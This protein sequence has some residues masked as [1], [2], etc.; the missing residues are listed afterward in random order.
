MRVA[1]TGGSGFTGQFVVDALKSRDLDYLLLDADL[2][3]RAAVDRA[4]QDNDFDYVIHLAARAFVDTS[5]WTSFYTV[6][7]IG[8]FNL[9]DAVANHRPGSRCIIASSAQ[10]Y[11]PGAE[12]LIAE[13]APP[14]PSNHYAISKLAMEQGAALWRDRLHIV[15][16]RPFNYT[17]IGQSTQYLIPKIVDHYRRNADVIELGNTWI[18]R[19]FGDVRSVAEAYLGLLLADNPPEVVNISTGVVWSIN[20]IMTILN[21]ISQHSIE[22]RVNPSFV[23]ANDVPI[24]GGDAA[25]LK[26][27]LQLWVPRE[28]ADT[29]EWMYR[30]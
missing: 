18:K 4:V 21:R 2:C 20:E 3:D 30:A 22:V 1:V 14:R 7:Q 28:L 27:T 11:G 23:R 19:D 12:G 5:D 9:L 24:L 26:D 6:N 10:I 16:T 13:S 29:L 15:V 17:G 8:T 25:A